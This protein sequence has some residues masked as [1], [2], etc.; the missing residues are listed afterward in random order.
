MGG[1]NQEFRTINVI[2]SSA[3]LFSLTWTQFICQ[4]GSELSPSPSDVAPSHLQLPS[5]LIIIFSAARFRNAVLRIRS[6]S[7]NPLPT[8]FFCIFKCIVIYDEWSPATC[9][10]HVGLA[11][12]DF[13]P[14]TRSHVSPTK[15]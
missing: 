2:A 15:I 11:L 14:S 12:F 4:L 1:D 6:P 7:Q 8:H 9:R 13:D 5:T 10:A 3:S